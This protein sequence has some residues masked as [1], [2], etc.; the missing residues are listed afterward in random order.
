MVT[1]T[2][3]RQV[4]YPDKRSGT[5]FQLGL[6]LLL[7]AASAFS[8]YRATQAQIGPEFLI[9]LLL[10]LVF[11]PW[12]PLLGYRI[13]S[14]NSA[15][16][17]LERDGIILRWGLRLEQIPI[18]DIL[19]V[20]PAEELTVPLPMPVLRWPGS[21][22]GM[23]RNPHAE[24]FSAPP[25]IEYLAGSRRGLVL[26]GTTQRIYA[27]SP[28][29]P[30]AFMNT[31]HRL[32]ELGSM[33]RMPPQSVYPTFLISRVWQ[34]PAAR[35][36][37]L[38]SLLLSLALLGWSLIAIPN[39]SQVHLGFTASASPGDLVPAVQL[40]LLPVLN[41]ILVAIDFFIGLFFF[42]RP[43]SQINAFIVWSAGALTPLLFLGGVFFVLRAG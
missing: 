14:L 28:I 30:Q 21:L 2:G 15:L 34:S 8:M 26:V 19:W 37:L 32:T 1:L 11:L 16:Y 35:I 5:I 13:Y 27:L 18:A 31:F 40:L 3:E 6:V 12:I 39:R 42:R 36:L 41:T 4:Y 17:S 24:R 10:S 20:Y 38:T 33:G 22:V 29:N 7:L 25:E 23:R 43:E 9:F